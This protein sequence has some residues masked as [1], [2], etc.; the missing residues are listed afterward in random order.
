V[1]IVWPAA[2]LLVALSPAAASA[3]WWLPAA[4]VLAAVPAFAARHLRPSDVDIRTSSALLG[5]ALAV[6]AGM[7]ATCAAVFAA[8]V[9]P[10][11]VAAI[12]FVAAVTAVRLVGLRL[13]GYWRRW[14]LG[15]LL[16]AGTAFVAVCLAIAPPEQPSEPATFD[17]NGVLLAAAVCFA[18]FARTCET[19]LPAFVATVMAGTVVAAVALH[20]LGP[21]R[22]GLTPTAAREVLAAADASVLAPVLGPVVLLATVPAA[23]QAL[24]PGTGHAARDEA[25]GDGIPA[26]RLD[27]LAV[28]VVAAVLA[29]VLPVA[30]LPA[31]TAASALGV[32]AVNAAVVFSRRR[33]LV[34]AATVVLAVTLLVVLPS[35]YLLAA[36]LAAGVLTAWAHHRRRGRVRT[37]TG[38]RVSR[39]SGTRGR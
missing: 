36:A 31:T 13:D 12:G 33:A 7:L 17:L 6:R 2:V 20:Q 19:R 23:L 10:G 39:P 11:P 3:G 16:I 9:V 28:A 26:G 24:T 25:A 18:L 22:L 37:G 29:G 35:R 14:C 4:V 32:V 15:L 30:G 27:L 21:V 5:L 8:Y 34:P 1:A 38:V